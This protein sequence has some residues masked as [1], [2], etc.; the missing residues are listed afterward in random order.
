VPTSPLRIAFVPGVTPDKWLR[1]WAD[2]Y[3]TPIEAVPI[4]DE[5]QLAVLRERTADMCLLRLPVER[6]GLHVI[7]LYTETPVV[8]VAKDHVI[9]ALDEV[10]TADLADE[11][12]ILPDAM[13]TKQV[14]EVA[15][16]GA[17]YVI[18]PMSIARLHHRKDVATRPVT[19]IEG[20]RIGLAWRAD[21][22]DERLEQFIGIVRGRTE[23]SSRTAPTPPTERPRRTAP[24]KAPRRGRGTKRRP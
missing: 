18:V 5:D 16:S 7:P 17:G 24:I 21:N 3:T 15:A 12:E 6:E 22:E 2:R 4:A 10:T 1:I 19:D 8:V 14:I 13:T 23:R 11:H 20:S 9:T